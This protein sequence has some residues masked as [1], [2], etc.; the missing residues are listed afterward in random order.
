MKTVSDRIFELLKERKM[1]QKEFA[2]KTGIAESTVSDWKKKRTNPVSDK[3]LII[4]EVLGVSPYYLL[5]GAEHKGERSRENITYVISK[6]SDVGT[7]IEKYQCLDRGMQRQLMGYLTAL[8]EMGN[9][10]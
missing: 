3:I 1:S 4:S 5:S 9:L 6:D 7:L 2:K 8:T 10:K